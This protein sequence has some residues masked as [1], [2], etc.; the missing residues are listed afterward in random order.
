MTEELQILKNIYFLLFTLVTVSLLHVSFFLLRAI[1]HLKKY[2][3]NH[4]DEAF[5]TEAANLFEKNQ[6]DELIAVCEKKLSD[7]PNHV[8]AL[9]YSIVAFYNE[10][11]YSKV[12]EFGERLKH[13]D[14][15]AE[16]GYAKSYLDKDKLNEKIRKALEANLRE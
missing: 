8:A 4:L 2:I 12:I 11:N 16:E 3:I 5:R 14:P 9:F 13:V 10:G 6:I 15:S 1:F 7:R